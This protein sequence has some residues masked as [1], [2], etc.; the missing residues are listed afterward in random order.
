[1]GSFFREVD[2]VAVKGSFE[3]RSNARW[4]QFG[5]I[6]GFW[7][8]NWEPECAPLP[9][10]AGAQALLSDPARRVKRGLNDKRKAVYLAL[11]MLIRDSVA[12]G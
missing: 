2:Y 7:T 1:M 10:E 6:K 12:A 9:V 5:L 11:C 3:E 4:K 8:E